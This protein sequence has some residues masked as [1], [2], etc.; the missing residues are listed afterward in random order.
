MESLSPCQNENNL[1]G[2]GAHPE[3]RYVPTEKK[4]KKE[5]SLKTKIPR[6][7]EVLYSGQSLDQDFQDFEFT[8]DYSSACKAFGRKQNLNF[9]VDEEI[10]KHFQAKT[11]ILQSFYYLVHC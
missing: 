9:Y 6:V 8:T 4:P 11:L 2:W 10:F 1:V 5:K 7:T 3:D